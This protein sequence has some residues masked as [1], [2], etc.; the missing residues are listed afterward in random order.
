MNLKNNI[1][2]KQIQ[3]VRHNPDKDSCLLEIDHHQIHYLFKGVYR[4]EHSCV[5][6]FAQIIYFRF[7]YRFRRSNLD[8][9]V[10]DF[11]NR[12]RT[13][14]TKIEQRTLSE[15]KEKNTHGLFGE[16][17]VPFQKLLVCVV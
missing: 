13:K 12:N 15:V 5:K 2:S 1:K 8:E 3:T 16:D 10:E 14:Y 17:P 6:I 7:F 11:W 9:P 4:C